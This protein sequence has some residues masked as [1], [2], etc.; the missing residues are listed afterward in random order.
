MFCTINF[1]AT[2]KLFDLFLNIGKL[3]FDPNNDDV[4]VKLFDFAAGQ[5]TRQ[6]TCDLF[7]NGK[8]ATELLP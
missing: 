4:R 2:S 6:L 5:L 7:M 1:T 8:I 3:F